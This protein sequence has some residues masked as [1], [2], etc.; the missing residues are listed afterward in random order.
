MQTRPEPAWVVSLS[1]PLKQIPCRSLACDR[2]RVE[3][4]KNPYLREQCRYGSV[5]FFVSKTQA[6]L[7]LGAMKGFATAGGQLRPADREALEG[8]ARHVSMPAPDLTSQT[9]SRHQPGA[10]P[11]LSH[12]MYRRY[13]LQLIALMASSTEPSMKRNWRLRW[14]YAADLA[15]RRLCSR[16]GETRRGHIDWVRPTMAAT[17]AEAFRG[18]DLAKT[19]PDNSCPTTPIPIP[20]WQ[21][22]SRALRHFL[23][24]P[25]PRVLPTTRKRF[26]FPRRSWRLSILFGGR[27]KSSRVSAYSTPSR[28]TSGV[29]LHRCHAPQRGMSGHILRMI[30]SWHMGICAESVGGSARAPSMARVLARLG[31]GTYGDS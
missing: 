18:M 19:L 9:W 8:A 7:T 11:G 27:M 13:I 24:K 28:R 21:P 4:A 12:A 14:G 15:Y 16:S 30:F 10:C 29:D 17:N 3:H 20:L 6:N 2:W 1:W 26:T 31:T 25:R 5:S 22:F 23:T